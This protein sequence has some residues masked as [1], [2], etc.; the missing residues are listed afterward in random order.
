M[1]FHICYCVFACHRVSGQG[2]IPISKMWFW[3][4]LITFVFVVFSIAFRSTMY[5]LNRFSVGRS[6]VLYP[7]V[8]TSGAV[9]CLWVQ[10]TGGRKCWKRYRRCHQQTGRT[11]KISMKHMMLGFLACSM[12]GLWYYNTREM[13]ILKSGRF[14][15]KRRACTVWTQQLNTSCAAC[16]NVDVC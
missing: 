15:K 2:N 7:Y 11:N 1:P 6:R 5:D 10:E 13:E 9:Q 3:Y 8:G 14:R 12:L 4:V 16:A